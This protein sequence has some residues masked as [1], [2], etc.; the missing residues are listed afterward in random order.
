M[1]AN[2]RA[3]GRSLWR[4]LLYTMIAL[5]PLACEERPAT[6]V[7][8]GVATD[9][10]SPPLDHVT[11]TIERMDEASGA[12]MPLGSPSERPVNAAGRELPGS[13]VAFATAKT[14]PK[15]RITLR[16]LTAD[17]TELMRRRAVLR[18]QQERTLFL[19]L[20]LTSRCAES[21]DCGEPLTCIEGRCQDEEVQA[22]ALPIYDSAGKA[23]ASFTCDSGTAFR[24]TGTGVALVQ[25]GQSCSQATD[26]CSEGTCYQ[27]AVFSPGGLPEAHGV[28]VKALVTTAAGL[29]VAGAELRLEDGPV[30]LV[31]QLRGPGPLPLPTG[32]P[33]GMTEVMS[34]AAA[35]S[36]A[37]AGKP[38]LYHVP[39]KAERMTRDLRMTIT[40]AGYAPQVVNVPYKANVVEYFVPVVLFPL[41]D[42]TFAVGAPR[43]VDIV[44][45]G[46]RTATLAIGGAGEAH[47]RYA[48][49][50]PRFAPGRGL[51]GVGTLLQA[52][53]AL[54]LEN[55]GAEP[56][57]PADTAISFGA[58]LVPLFG[59]DKQA[60][61]Y[62]LDLQGQW[63]KRPAGQLQ[64]SHGGFWTA[65]RAAPR[66]ACVRGR[67]SL[68][69]GKPCPGA[70]V[71]LLGP[72]GVGS[73]DSAGA[74]GSFCGSVAQG[75]ASLIVVGNTARTIYTPASER[76]GLHCGLAQECPYVGE[77]RVDA[78]EDC[79]GVPPVTVPTRGPGAPCASALECVGVSSCHQGFCVGEGFL[80]VSMTW[81]GAVNLG[82]HVKPPGDRGALSPAQP[83]IE[84]V[85]RMDVEQC[86]PPC[87]G[88]HH[89]ESVL[90]QEAK[91]SVGGYEVWVE[92]SAGGASTT[93]EVEIFARGASIE[94]RTVAVPADAAGRSET[95]TFQL[96]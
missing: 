80:R 24:N 94:R 10:P 74:D 67:V 43:S 3:R 17:Q 38:G 93:A 58:E 42:K 79:S 95:V 69:E 25:P 81:S 87:S 91:G 85:G 32:T 71:R 18:L 78:E 47:V 57:L 9:L 89:I 7:V 13:L 1:R 82:L 46:G 77:I 62:A 70:R 75:E 53:P 30:T 35:P 59:A 28:L 56:G 86:A 88:E 48:L 11:M 51:A 72:D 92:N 5:S 49:L 15:I 84:G 2:S 21:A 29:P 20:G 31:R 14:P 66:P 60:G 61:L 8:I 16:A 76:A 26:V 27:P 83:E 39:G 19:R 55:V 41:V 68:A 37:I 36:Q 50:D 64:P 44:G 65:G 54:Y 6:Q 96:P 52:R 23:E 22:A 34:P 12:F 90:L 63:Q 45:L 33:A 40:A 4:S 73:E